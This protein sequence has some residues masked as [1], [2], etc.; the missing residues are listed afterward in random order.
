MVC[1]WMPISPW[2]MILEPVPW[3]Q[4]KLIR[5]FG[6]ET[7]ICRVCPKRPKAT[8][9]TQPVGDLRFCKR[10]EESPGHEE[11]LSW[12][13]RRQAHAESEVQSKH[14]PQYVRKWPTEPQKQNIRS[15][16]KE[17][18]LSRMS[19]STNSNDATSSSALSARTSDLRHVPTCIIW[20]SD[21]GR[22]QHS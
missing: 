7:R 18:T 9:S 14:Q 3:V 11:S 21:G 10:N 6:G 1:A 12:S 2:C 5:I 15:R 13:A 16:L 19:L 20:T 4:T 22:F 8:Q 17:R